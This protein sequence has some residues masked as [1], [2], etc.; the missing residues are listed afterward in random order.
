MRA[1]KVV[2]L[3]LLAVVAWA[4]VSYADVTISPPSG[5]SGTVITV[6]GITTCEGPAQPT[7]IFVG[8]DGRYAGY[9][10]AVPFTP[11]SPV[12]L[13]VP[14]VLPGEYHIVPNCGAME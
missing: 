4:G 12:T 11:P 3:A 1:P 8:P 13:V 7:V 6:S 10:R 9:N 5:P 2:L 14:N